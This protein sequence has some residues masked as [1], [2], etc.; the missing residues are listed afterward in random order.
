MND[1]GTNAAAWE[2]VQRLG[3]IIEG[4]LTFAMNGLVSDT[5]YFYRW[6]ASNSVGLAWAA[7]SA[8][9]NTLALSGTIEKS[10]A[11]S[12]DDA[13]E[14]QGGR[15]EAGNSLISTDLELVFDH[16]GIRSNQVV[17][18]RFVNLPLPRLATIREAW[19]QF[20]ADETTNQPGS[21]LIRG[22]ARD[23]PATFI[24]VTTNISG[25][26]KSTN[27][28]EWAPPAW[29]LLGESGAAQRTPDLSAILQEQVDRPG[30]SSGNAMVFI[31]SGTGRRVAD[32][33]DKVGGSPA[34]LHVSWGT[35]RATESWQSRYFGPS[36][37][38]D[39]LPNADPDG[40]GLNNLEEYIAGTNP[41][42][43]ASAPRLQAQ[44]GPGKTAI[45]SY[46]TEV[47][48]GM[49]YPGRT[50]FYDL[51]I[52]LDP[53]SGTWQ[54]V[55]QQTS[56]PGIGSLHFYTNSLTESPHFYRLRLRLE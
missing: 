44:M 7:T 32:S 49:D 46:M 27:A 34:R 12:S 25:R 30:W 53:G 39:S 8:A 21:L 22:E 23:N 20:T 55:P 19:I 18:L 26:P 36:P 56:I 45:L 24:N 29:S 40:D 50:R 2:Q 41:K 6:S 16:E 28:V 11:S 13:E 42:D 52:S 47:A 14:P 4:P 10:I 17:G 15:M 48:G 9:L 31:I 43:G 5:T 38:A 3:A 35:A 33:F 37:G 54:G 1:A 51:Q